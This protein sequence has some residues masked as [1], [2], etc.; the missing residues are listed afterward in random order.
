MKAP[1][2][3]GGSGKPPKPKVVK[4]KKPVARKTVAPVTDTQS[5]GQDYGTKK[6]KAYKKTKEYKKAARPVVGR[7]VGSTTG[8]TFKEVGKAKKSLEGVGK[9]GLGKAITA[10]GDILSN[11]IRRSQEATDVSR[12][13]TRLMG[14]S[15]S[16]AER[17]ARNVPKDAANIVVNAIPSTVHLIDTAI[18]D[19]QDPLG[20]HGVTR[21]GHELAAPY[22][23]LA[24][25][26]GKMLVEKPVTSALL[27]TGP[28]RGASRGVGAV[29]RR[30]A[31]GRAAKKAAAT[32]RA[33][34]KTSENTRIVEP[35]RWSPDPVGKAVQVAVE[36]RKARKIRKAYRKA[37][38]LDKKGQRTQ[39]AAVR[40]EAAQKAP[41]RVHE[42]QVKRRVDEL[43]ATNEAVRRR[44]AGQVDQAVDAAV[45]NKP[46]VKMTRK[47]RRAQRVKPT[48]V[49]SLTTQ[50][51][52]R[53]TIADL[54][55]YLAELEQA[56]KHGDLTPRQKASNTRLRDQI[57]EAIKHP[58]EPALI[59]AAARRYR[60]VERPI[61]EKLVKYRMLD[62]EEAAKR[63][64]L[65]FAVRSLG[66]TRDTKPRLTKEG[67]ERM[68]L[69][70][71]RGE[72]AGR[73]QKALADVERTRAVLDRAIAD[74]RVHEVR[75]GGTVSEARPLP[76][77]SLL[78]RKANPSGR[79]VVQWM[80]QVEARDPAVVRSA[81]G[82]VSLPSPAD[83]V[84]RA[85]AA[86]DDALAVLER[87]R[88]RAITLR[89]REKDLKKATKGKVLKRAPGF[90]DEHGNPLSAAQIRAERI[91]GAEDAVTGKL[92]R[93][94]V[95]GDPAY[96]SHA[97]H[98]LK[99]GSFFR[100]SARPV[101]IGNKPFTG[102]T[103]TR[104]G[105]DASTD[106]LH[107]SAR[108]LQSLVDA[109]EGHLRFL[110][111]MALR[112]PKGTVVRGTRDRVQA[113]IDKATLDA[114]GDALPGA[115]RYRIVRIHPFGGRAAQLDELLNQLNRHGEL[116]S[117]AKGEQNP[118]ITALEDALQGKGD[119][120]FAAI[121]EEAAARLEQHLRVLG[122]SGG[123]VWQ[124]LNTLWRKNVLAFSLRW[125]LSNVTEATVR[126]LVAG[127]RP[128][129]RA[130]MTRTLDRWMKDDPDA[131]E[132]F[133]ASLGTG[134]YGFTRSTQRHATAEEFMDPARHG[135]FVRNAARLAGTI[136][137]TPV[138][139]WVPK[140]WSAWTSH[141]MDSMGRV[142]GQ[143]KMALA[144][145]KLRDLHQESRTF[146]KLSE[147][148]VQEAL[149][150][151]KGTPTQVE[152]ARFARR[153]Y[154][155]YEAHSPQM[156]KWIEMY[157]P[158]VAWTLNAA[159]FI[160]DV[161]PR[162]HPVLTA[163]M[164]DIVNSQEEWLKEVG[165]WIGEQDTLP[166]YM[167]GDVPVGGG[168]L[169]NVAKYTP[170]S[171]LQDPIATAASAFLPSMTNLIMAGK[172]GLDPF[173]NPLKESR[174]EAVLKGMLG[175]IVPAPILSPG[176]SGIL[177]RL[178]PVQTIPA[179]R[180]AYA[181]VK[182][183]MERLD[184]QIDALPA[185]KKTEPFSK[186]YRAL[187]DQRADL[188]A[189]RDRL[190]VKA[191]FKEDP[192][193]GVREPLRLLRRQIRD[194]PR[195]GDELG[196][197]SKTYGENLS[198][199]QSS[200]AQLDALK[201]SLLPPK[202]KKAKLKKRPQ[203]T[204]E[205]VRESVQ[206]LR[207]RDIRQEVLDEIARLREQ[208]KVDRGG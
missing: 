8:T 124:T 163:F 121:P 34:A 115:R 87:E 5:S 127:V 90:V 78:G 112:D 172:Y 24:K 190:L 143:F 144:G 65:P 192:A 54:K 109:H 199:L 173:G 154:G 17:A 145:K 134:H 148:A 135:R 71:R 76:S 106:A 116:H 181:R 162:D 60:E 59:E 58:Q 37:D 185:E 20:R 99:G 184:K 74:A 25:D 1:I 107:A 36:K 140:A 114:R 21:L 110:D 94:P 133:L 191:G 201:A 13:G 56:Y 147:K 103:V 10:T 179:D 188:Q 49:I 79:D 160:F 48:A 43:V 129:D 176:S 85:I 104:T 19:Q 53:A 97:P 205:K 96:V 52:T 95:K 204:A 158:F 150:G 15:N 156:R 84:R 149:Q 22:E 14:Y 186:E 11:I 47:A 105:F 73:V 128:G 68:V 167:L 29:A 193:I 38:E 196:Y 168:G 139:N 177:E 89:Q 152:M 155:K 51:I 46:T 39:A 83:R 86:H 113:A 6:A 26:P 42:D 142:E 132:A 195:E 75:S 197:E 63:R 77:R 161:L 32:E 81:R 174:E 40:E 120:P 111:E 138:I 130:L 72:V 141:V 183:T 27:V 117:P 41:T 16:V 30:G 55:A 50:N 9:G 122:S 159:R 7:G 100:D 189:E 119:G 118:V 102:T 18:K 175:F 170:G 82:R 57:R 123:H 12:G 64:E 203:T 165:L 108:R 187:L 146:A 35:R 33:P 101:S 151:L 169:L 70:E 164:A 44:H 202:P 80:S 136:N 45:R 180:V 153:T 137:R 91:R 206:D 23:E 62:A 126:S 166:T 178:N 171:L 61:T 198:G 182:A 157:T 93:T 131:A 125:G 208:A 92:T 4:R 69:K 3:G 98:L 28:V 67:T 194:L 88:A 2:G 200:V 31:L 66:A 207:E